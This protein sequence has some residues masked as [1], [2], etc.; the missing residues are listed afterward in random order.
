MRIAGKFTEFMFKELIERVETVIDEQRNERHDQISRKIEAV[1][2]SDVKMEAF[3][4]KKLAGKEV[5]R[6]LLEFGFPAN[7]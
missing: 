4:K 3:M 6:N 2:D 5:D 1:L 7:I